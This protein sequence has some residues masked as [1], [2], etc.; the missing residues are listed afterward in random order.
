MASFA[1]QLNIGAIVVP[2]A[3]VRPQSISAG[4]VTGTSLDRAAHGMAESMVLHQNLGAIGGTPT[5]VAVATVLYHAPDN[6]T[7]TPYIQAGGTAQ[8]TTPTGTAGNTDQVLNVNLSSAYRY[9]QAR[10]VATFGG[11]TSPTAL[12]AVTCVLGGERLVPAV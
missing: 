2:F 6:A 10:L 9:V 11:G 3:A 1:T 4:T 5:S 8:V 7:W 12:G